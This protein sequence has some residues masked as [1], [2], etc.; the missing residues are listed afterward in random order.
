MAKSALSILLV[1]DPAQSRPELM[2]I[3]KNE[4]PCH[5][6]TSSQEA[7][8][9]LAELRPSVIMVSGSLLK[10]TSLQFLEACQAISPTAVRVLLT[11]NPQKD[12]VEQKLQ[13]HLVH[14]FFLIPAEAQVLHLQLLE[15]LQLYQN[16]EA[17]KN[18][19]NLAQIDSLTHLFNKRA[20]DQKLNVEYSRS[21]RSASAFSLLMIDIDHFKTINDSEGH[22]AGDKV[23]QEIS[24]LMK[25]KLRP[26][27]WIFRLGG[28]EFAA[29]LPSAPSTVAFEIAERLRTA[30]ERMYQS[31]DQVT[32]S[33]GIST[34]PENSP[35]QYTLLQQA[36]LALYEAKSRGRNQTIIASPI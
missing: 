19:E 7:L 22:Q 15:V 1:D 36:D 4:G 6:F 17:Q 29:L 5:I 8:G 34:F 13:A 24:Q 3:L 2:E 31:P 35:D 25:S 28:D 30:I 12:E 16:L 14:R 10:V 23:L 27:D 33:I 20:F 32:V 18:F 9:R 11:D 21:K 26:T